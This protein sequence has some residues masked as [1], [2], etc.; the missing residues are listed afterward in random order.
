MVCRRRRAF[1]RRLLFDE[2]VPRATIGTAPHPFLLLPAALL[3]RE[4]RLRRLHSAILHR[5]AA[6]APAFRPGLAPVRAAPYPP[7]SPSLMPFT[8]TTR[9][10]S[11]ITGCNGMVDASGGGTTPNINRPGRTRSNQTRESRSVAALLAA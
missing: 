6:R 8:A 4:H 10:R 1:G 2:R 5:H 11:D 7:F 3:A 9:L